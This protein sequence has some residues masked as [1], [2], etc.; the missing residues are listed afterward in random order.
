MGQPAHSL[1]PHTGGHSPIRVTAFLAGRFR[2]V[3]VAFGH[4]PAPSAVEEKS[5]VGQEKF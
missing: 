4:A 1:M 2:A 5:R 3:A